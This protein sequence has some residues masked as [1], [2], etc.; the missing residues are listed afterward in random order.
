M[1]EESRKYEEINEEQLEDVSGGWGSTDTASYC[2][3]C[4][5][6]SLIPYKFK[7][8]ATGLHCDSCGQTIK[9]DT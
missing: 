1:S 9:Y 3:R 7:W 4:G 8:G 5:K 2:E 6:F